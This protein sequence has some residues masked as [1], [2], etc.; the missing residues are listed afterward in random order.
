MKYDVRL[1]RVGTADEEG[2][3]TSLDSCTHAGLV[4]GG[5]SLG[6]FPN[7]ILLE[8]FLKIGCLFSI[9]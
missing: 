3:S 6:D 4:K 8:D 7:F 1:G 2:R 5:C 9:K